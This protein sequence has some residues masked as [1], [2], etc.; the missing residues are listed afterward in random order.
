MKLKT[1]HK[2]WMYQIYQEKKLCTMFITSSTILWTME[3]EEAL[4][5]SKSDK[6][7]KRAQSHQ[8]ELLNTLSQMALKEIPK[9]IDR[10]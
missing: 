8:N 9:K 7:A 1:V 3:V 6:D 10:Y 4:A 5:L 2:L